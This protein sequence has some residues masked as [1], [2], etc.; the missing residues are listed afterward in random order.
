MAVVLK[1]TEPVRVPGVRIPLPPPTDTFS[2]A[3]PCAYLS[4]RT[5]RP[6]PD[7]HVRRPG[8]FWPSLPQERLPAPVSSSVT[9]LHKLERVYLRLAV[10]M[11]E[12]GVMRINRRSLYGMFG[13]RVGSAVVRGRTVVTRVTRGEAALV[14]SER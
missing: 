9:P 14:R 4:K 5:L 1:T 7:R 3:A 10:E 2:V 8:L 12:Q 11:V 6:K 13:R